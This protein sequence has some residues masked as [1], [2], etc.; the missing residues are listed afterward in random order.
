MFDL[1]L[2]FA[3]IGQIILGVCAFLL[4]LVSIPMMAANLFRMRWHIQSLPGQ[5]SR[6]AG[7]HFN[8]IF[9][10]EYLSSEGL[11]ARHKFFYWL[12]HALAGVLCG[13]AAVALALAFPIPM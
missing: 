12:K 6:L 7:N 8:V 13:L 10:P 11:I 5:S 4:L 2:Y 3:V 1:I 9:F